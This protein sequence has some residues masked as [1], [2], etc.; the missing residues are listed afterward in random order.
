[1]GQ[2]RHPPCWFHARFRVG[3]YKAKV[4]RLANLVRERIQNAPFSGS[5]GNGRGP[6]PAVLIFVWRLI[7]AATR[8]CE[9][10]AEE[11]PTRIRESVARPWRRLHCRHGPRLRGCVL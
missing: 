2:R 4:K 3:E 11:P 1:M 7:L 5:G 6:G 8:S 9:V 10:L